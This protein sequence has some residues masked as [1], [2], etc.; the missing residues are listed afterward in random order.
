MVA[1]PT[2]DRAALAELV[3]SP[4]TAAHVTLMVDDVAQLD[5]VD[6]VRSSPAVPVRV[7]L[8]IDAGLRLGGQHV[9]PKRSPR[10]RH[11][12]RPPAGPRSSPSVLGSPWSE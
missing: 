6:S 1:Y 9:G 12:G 2:V 4:S 11:R 3:G 10:P 7:A 8:D 5:V